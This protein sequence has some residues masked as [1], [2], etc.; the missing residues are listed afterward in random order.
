L[1]QQMLGG[2]AEGSHPLPGAPVSA[3]VPAHAAP[4]APIAVAAEPAATEEKES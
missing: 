3:A 1:A 2:G 4:G